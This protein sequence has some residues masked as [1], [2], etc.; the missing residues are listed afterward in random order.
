ME[1]N[2]AAH[3]RNL[4]A[5][6]TA[7]ATQRTGISKIAI[8]NTSGSLTFVQIF[9]DVAANITLGTTR[10]VV[11]IPVAS[12]AWEHVDFYPQEALFLTAV[13]AYAT[14]TVEGNTGSG[15]GVFMQGWIN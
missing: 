14:T 7:V 12:N 4:N 15:N 3:Y 11:S 1:H 13:T 8:T 6:A 2:Q 10:P 9:N 5:T